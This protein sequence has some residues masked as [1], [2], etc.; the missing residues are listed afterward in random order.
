MCSTTSNEC[1][2]CKY[3]YYPSG[4]VCLSCDTRNCNEC[5][6]KTGD[7]GDVSSCFAEHTYVPEGG[8][9]TACKAEKCLNCDGYTDDDPGCNKCAEDII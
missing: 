8:Y 7:C 3:D 2:E 5:D 6:T 1:V 9:C 4:T